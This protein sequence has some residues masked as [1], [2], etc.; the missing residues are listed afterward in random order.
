MPDRLLRT[1][2]TT[3]LASAIAVVSVTALAAGPA[4]AV[5]D[6]PAEPRTVRELLPVL[7]DLYRQAEEAGEAYHTTAER[8]VV[9]RAE[10]RR[11]QLALRQARS[12]LNESRDEAGRLA[13]RQYRGESELSAYLGL[14]LARDPQQA[15]DERHLI[16][17]AS[18]GSA[19]TIARLRNSELRADDLAARSRVALTVKR[20]L[21]DRQRR[22]HDRLQE[23]L[24]SAQALLAR[25]SAVERTQLERLE[26]SETDEAQRRLL[27]SGALGASTRKPSRMGGLAVEYAVHQIGRP[28]VWGATGPYGFDCSGL[29]SRA[30]ATAGRPIPRT[31]QEQ[32]ARLS[33]VPLGALRPGDL[34]IYFPKATHV[35]MY[36]GNGLVVQ[37][38]RPGTRVKVS[39]IAANPVLGAVRPDPASGPLLSYAPP[40]LPK[41]ARAGSDNGYA[42]ATAP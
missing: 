19:A 20:S 7:R 28:Y 25:L 39:P 8:L 23:R 10:T 42:S 38:P 1:L 11:L 5:P 29:T 13:R 34:V 37:A 33:R 40:M 30:W 35:A 32:W 27:E 26:Q 22:Q 14:L 6:G 12:A 9:Q 4:A 18:S 2:R 31:S 41:H 3:A 17:R 21:A 24:E 36:L 15:L 16:E